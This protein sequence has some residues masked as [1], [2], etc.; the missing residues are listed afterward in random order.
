M[1]ITTEDIMKAAKI[2]CHHLEE[3]G[4]KEVHLPQSVYWSIPKEYEYDAYVEPTK[5]TL[6]DLDEDWTELNK[7]I[8][9][10]NDPVGYGLVW[11]AQIIRAVGQNV[12]C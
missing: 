6:G 8:E 1:N 4:C 2:L 12:A 7:I 10:T 5:H 3:S 11:L 9:G